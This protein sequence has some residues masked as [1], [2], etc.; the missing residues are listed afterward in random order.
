MTLVCEL[1]FIRITRVVFENYFTRCVCETFDIYDTWVTWIIAKTVNRSFRTNNNYSIIPR[2]CHMGC[3]CNDHTAQALLS[4]LLKFWWEWKSWNV[5]SWRIGYAVTNRL[6]SITKYRNDKSVLSCIYHVRIWCLCTR[7]SLA[8]ESMRRTQ[9]KSIIIII[10]AMKQYDCPQK[11]K[12]HTCK[13][14]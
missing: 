8:H 3:G 2:D 9:S 1:H 6:N 5:L 14:K 10:S 4:I 11:N 7:A 12:N 13:G